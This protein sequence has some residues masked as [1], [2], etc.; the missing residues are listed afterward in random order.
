[1]PREIG[2][3]LAVA[4]MTL[5]A[6]IM[7][8]A[9]DIVYGADPRYC[10]VWSREFVRI[11][12]V[13]NTAILADLEAP[14]EQR[15]KA[16]E[17]VQPEVQMHL[18]SKNYSWCLNQDEMPGLP[19]V[20]AASDDAFIEF[21]INLDQEP[22]VDFAE[23]TSVALIQKVSDAWCESEYRTYDAETSTV[24]RSGSGG[25]RTPCAAAFRE[26]VLNGDDG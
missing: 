26:R 6:L 5:L 3:F 16:H 11:A 20:P 2:Y 19:D 12:H 13:N 24:I 22:S 17:F 7:W 9:F 15:E 4:S 25:E 10:N 1:M 21:I 23:S 18:L 14:P 8:G